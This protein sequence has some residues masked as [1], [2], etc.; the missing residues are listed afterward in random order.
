VEIEAQA[1]PGLVDIEEV[2]EP[3]AEEVNEPGIGVREARG[4]VP[5]GAL[6][7]VQRRAGDEEVALGQLADALPALGEQAID[8]R[9]LAV[10][11]LVRPVGMAA[12]ARPW[13]EL[14]IAHPD[15]HAGLAH[16]QAPRDV[17]QR[18]PLRPQAPGFLAFAEL[19]PVPHGLLPSR[20]S[21]AVCYGGVTG[22]SPP[23]I[24]GD[25]RARGATGAGDIRFL[26]QR[27]SA[28]S[29]AAPAQSRE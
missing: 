18:V 1:Q 25:G 11:Q 4:S 17:E 24:A 6:A 29:P 27:L 7:C 26:P 16:A 15:R 8:L 20:A 28:T 12:V 9:L 22:G 21:K 14:D 10:S 3:C 2:P 23:S 13:L 5:L 19:A